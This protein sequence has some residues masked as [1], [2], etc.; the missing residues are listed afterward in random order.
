MTWHWDIKYIGSKPGCGQSSKVRIQGPDGSKHV[1]PRS[2]QLLPDAKKAFTDK[3]PRWMVVSCTEIKLVRE[4]NPG[5]VDSMSDWAI[6]TAQQKHAE[7][8]TSA[9]TCTKEHSNDE[10][11]DV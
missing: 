10:N 1:T 5:D 8:Q 4:G 11:C 9:T 6:W 2:P 7:D 3:M